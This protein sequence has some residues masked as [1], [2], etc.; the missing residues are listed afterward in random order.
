MKPNNI[1]KQVCCWNERLSGLISQ[2]EKIFRALH[3]ECLN[4]RVTPSVRSVRIGTVLGESCGSLGG[5]TVFIILSLPSPLPSPPP[6]LLLPVSRSDKLLLTWLL[7]W[8]PKTRHSWPTWLFSSTLKK[9]SIRRGTVKE[10]A[11][12][13]ASVGC[14]WLEAS[15][16]ERHCGLLGKT[17]SRIVRLRHSTHWKGWLLVDWGFTL[18]KVTEKCK[19]AITVMRCLSGL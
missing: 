10:G 17:L 16:A 12:M 19:K 4:A 1:L 9:T 8:M 14:L 3:S 2:S 7:F 5:L 6:S 15:G 13:W 11:Y 18:K